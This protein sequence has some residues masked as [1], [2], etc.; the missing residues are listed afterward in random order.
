MTALL[1]RGSKVRD[2]GKIVFVFVFFF[3]NFN[4]TETFLTKLIHN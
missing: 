4:E 3:P 2:K 1:K